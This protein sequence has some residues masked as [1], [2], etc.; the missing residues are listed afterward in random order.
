MS[1]GA[2]VELLGV[3]VRAGRGARE[4][5]SAAEC[6]LIVDICS[7]VIAMGPTLPGG[8]IGR[9]ARCGTQLL[10]D[11][12]VPGVDAALRT[13]LAEAVEAIVVRRA[14]A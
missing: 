14:T 3:L 13:A 6:D 10:L 7:Q 9:A 4:T 2:E 5:L 11:H 12:A 8:Q 1:S